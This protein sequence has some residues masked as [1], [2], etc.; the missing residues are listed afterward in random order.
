MNIINLISQINSK[1]NAFKIYLCNYKGRPPDC[2]KLKIQGSE[3]HPLHRYKERR[4]VINF[5]L[6]F[7]LLASE[8]FMCDSTIL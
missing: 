2:R 7:L 4:L 5:I 8:F 3:N 6:N 1:L